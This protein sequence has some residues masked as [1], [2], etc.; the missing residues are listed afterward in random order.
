MKKLISLILATVFLG[1]MVASPAISQEMSND[2][3]VLELKAMKEK[4]KQVES[5]L[6]EVSKASTADGET[7]NQEITGQ[8]TGGVK[9]L[10]KR[11]TQLEDAIGREVEGD[12]WYDRIQISGLVEVEA[13]YGKTDFKDPATEDEET[14]DVDLAVVE[15]VV[16]A[17][18]AKHVDGHVLFKWE[19]DDLFVDEGFITL[20]G[21]EDFPAYL[22]AGRQYIPFGYFESNFITDPTTLILGETNEGAVVGGYR[23]S[24]EMV[25]ISVGAF[26][27]RVKEIGKDDKISNF[28][29]AL[30]VTPFEN[31]MLGASYTSNLA[32]ANSLS[33]Q[34]TDLDGDGASDNISSFVGGYSAFVAASF[35]DRF[36]IIGEYVSAA[37]EFKAGELYEVADTKMRQPAAWNLEFGFAVSDSW[38]IA[39]KYAGSEDGDAG[40][41]E[42]LPESQYGAVVNWGIFENTNLAFEYLHGEFENDF[43]ETDV[44]TTQ[45]AIEF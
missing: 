13:S 2:E 26:N 20:V 37:D 43:Q 16:D 28:V 27:G 19:E 34:V 7:P 14:S 33:E 32:A 44:L 3:L 38:E 18:I 30:V 35:L 31:I 15:L 45:L 21:S 1:I 29:G 25:D 5:Q 39:V 17:K 42:F 22:I 12:K 40:G 6:K 4:I 41:G 10:E 36:K 11:I 24:G 9:G 23:F 8:K